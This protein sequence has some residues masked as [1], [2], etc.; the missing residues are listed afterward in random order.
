[1]QLPCSVSCGLFFFFRSQ[2]F[3]DIDIL[4]CNERI[5]NLFLLQYNL[6]RR[7]RNR[8]GGRVWAYS[9]S[10]INY[11]RRFYQEN[12]ALGMLS[13]SWYFVSIDHLVNKAGKAYLHIYII[14]DINFL[15]SPGDWY[16]TRFVSF[17]VVS[18]AAVLFV[19]MHG[20]A[21]PHNCCWKPNH[22]LSRYLAS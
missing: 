22:I 9:R 8:S 20:S 3:S 13:L 5:L 10:T 15:R 2:L 17:M 16:T 12:D 21:P 1:M 6:I 4:A 14:G 18:S 7:D 19:V 11:T